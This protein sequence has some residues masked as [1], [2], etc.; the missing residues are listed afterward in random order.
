MARV[1]HLAVALSEQVFERGV[2]AVVEVR[3]A[4]A[5]RAQRGRQ[6]RAVLVDGRGAADVVRVAIGE[7]GALRVAAG[8][9][10]LRRPEELLAVRLLGGELARRGGRALE[11]H[12]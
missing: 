10:G 11:R 6:E 3:R 5:D 2:A 8:A 9:R 7:A 4:L 1:A 12:E